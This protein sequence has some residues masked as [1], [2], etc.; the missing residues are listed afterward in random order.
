MYEDGTDTQHGHPVDK[1]IKLW[2]VYERSLKTVS[3]VSMMSDQMPTAVPGSFG[4]P[5]HPT[6]S[7]PKISHQDTI[8]A[9][10]PRRI[11]SNGKRRA[12]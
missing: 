5:V 7:M 8:V 2:K 9:A 3:E 10:V 4:T 6:L 1:T 12:K 11:Y